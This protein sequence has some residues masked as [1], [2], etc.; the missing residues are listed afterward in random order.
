MPGVLRLPDNCSGH[1]CWPPRPSATASPDVLT[2]GLQTERYGDSM[3]AHCCPPPCHGGTHVGKRNVLVN[4]RTM[5][6][7]GDPISCGS[8]GQQCS[9]NV[10]ANP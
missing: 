8:V 10:L 5:Q 6:V 2:N 4:G 3:T 1:G 9:P 7:R